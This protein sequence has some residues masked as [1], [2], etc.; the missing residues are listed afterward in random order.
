MCHSP[1]PD[2]ASLPWLALDQA[3]V[4]NWLRHLSSDLK[5]SRVDLGLDAGGRPRGQPPL[6]RR[7]GTIRIS[8]P[9]SPSWPHALQ[10]PPAARYRLHFERES[11]EELERRKKV[12]QEKILEPVPESEKE[13]DI[14]DVYR[15]GSGEQGAAVG[16]GRRLEG[17]GPS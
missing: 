14:Q 5:L 13:L 6:G 17:P 3:S 12:A 1:P 9:G 8:A 15:S 16:R 11:R 7:T 4:T 10:L 2:P